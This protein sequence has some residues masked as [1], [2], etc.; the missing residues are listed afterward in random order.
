MDFR[1]YAMAKISITSSYRLKTLAIVVGIIGSFM[2]APLVSSPAHADDRD[3]CLAAKDD[4]GT[5]ACTRAIESG[6]W[7]GYDLATLYTRRGFIAVARFDLGA[8]L[9]D[10]NQALRLD[11]DSAPAHDGR[12]RADWF[13]PDRAIIDF[14]AAI[15]LDPDFA[16]AYA[17][18]GAAYR[19][20]RDPDRAIADLDRAI[21]LDPKN[22]KAYA[23]RALA[24]RDKGDLDRAIADFST[25]IGLDPRDHFAVFDRGLVYQKKGDLDRALADYDTAI[26]RGPFTRAFEVRGD[27]YRAK[28][29]Y[30]RAI[31]DFDEAIRRDASDAV[32]YRGRGLTEQAK[33]DSA[34]AAADFAAA[35]RLST[36]LGLPIPTFTALHA[37]L[38]VIAIV[39]GFVVAFGMLRANRLP[40]LTAVFFAS[41]AAASA[42]GF[43][44][45][46]PHLDPEYSAGLISLVLLAVA[47]VAVFV[48]RSTGPWRWVY[49]LATLSALY[50]DVFVGIR[51]ALPHL[52]S[53]LLLLMPMDP[54]PVFLI[55]PIAITAMFVLVAAL[56]L[57]KFHPRAGVPA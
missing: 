22:A 11:P 56:A 27:A 23:T 4:D 43:L 36:I 46:G 48:G 30:D 42:S 47:L 5:A 16:H 1:G 7:Q 35:K 57:R 3:T 50:L 6:H 31:A 51:Q 49:I 28:G 32:A 41:A 19:L 18:R 53:R 34:A 8:A 44:F 45:H 20:K 38:G 2:A 17:D 24:Y 39:S 13:Q 55:V 52:P 10:F 9:A 21:Q 25:A 54:A 26:E 29:D 40:R 15:R 14:D 33:G 37:A 12:G